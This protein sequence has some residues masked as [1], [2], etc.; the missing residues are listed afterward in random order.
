[1]QARPDWFDA[2]LF[3]V[4]S[5]WLDV[6][7]HTVHYVD[8]GSGPTLLMLHGNPT[9]SFLYRR[10]ISGLR[11]DFRCV[12][13]DYPGFGLSTAAPGYGFTVAEHSGLVRRFVEALDLTEVTSVVQDWGGPIGMGAA[14]S[15][16]D[17]YAGGGQPRVEALRARC[18]ARVDAVVQRRDLRGVEPAED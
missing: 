7:G 15:D 10:L 11:D 13:L 14:I 4:T 6:D 2:D 16:P 18:P 3:P 12:A 9:W 5:R 8:E 1:M 17:R